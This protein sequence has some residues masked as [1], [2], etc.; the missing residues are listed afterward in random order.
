MMPITGEI[1]CTA[2]IL[3]KIRTAFLTYQDVTIPGI[4]DEPHKIISLSVSQ[5]EIKGL[6]T[7]SLTLRNAVDDKERIKSVL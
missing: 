4:L 5:S 1:T 6:F 7:C 2:E 3:N